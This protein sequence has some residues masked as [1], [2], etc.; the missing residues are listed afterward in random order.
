M[1]LCADSLEHPA[2]GGQVSAATKR[3]LLQDP[4]GLAA[5]IVDSNPVISI[6]AAVEWDCLNDDGKE[7]IIAIVRETVR[8]CTAGGSHG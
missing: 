6:F 1:R 3:Q 2:G 7:W 8:R 5:D 4:A